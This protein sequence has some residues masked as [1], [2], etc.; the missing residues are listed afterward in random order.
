MALNTIGNESKFRA[1][2]FSHISTLYYWLHFLC[3]YSRSSC[4][5]I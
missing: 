5:Y 1:P 4:V 2:S 3:T